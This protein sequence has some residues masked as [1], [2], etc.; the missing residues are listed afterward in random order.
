MQ[1]LTISTFQIKFETNQ[2][3]LFIVSNRDK[4]VAVD[5]LRFE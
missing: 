4:K 1:I 2:Q 3:N 5:W